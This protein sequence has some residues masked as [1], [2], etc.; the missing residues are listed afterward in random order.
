M[1]NEL[2]FGCGENCEFLPFSGDPEMGNSW[3]IQLGFSLQNRNKIPRM[4]G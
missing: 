3:D 2:M 4:R 1:A